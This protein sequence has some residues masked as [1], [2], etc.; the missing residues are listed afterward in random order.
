MIFPLEAAEARGFLKDKFSYILSYV[1][2]VQ[3]M[4]TYKKALEK[5][6]HPQFCTPYLLTFEHSK[7]RPVLSLVLVTS[8]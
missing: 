8:Q 7:C 6:L 2:K 1:K 4:D 3:K 5:G